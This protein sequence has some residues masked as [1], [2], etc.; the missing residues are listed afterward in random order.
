VDEDDVE[1]SHRKK[2]GFHVHQT[3]GEVRETFLC[4]IRQVMSI[5]G[6]ESGR[7]VVYWG[8]IMNIQ[9]ECP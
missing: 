8:G 1:G 6:K 7:S 9:I 5:I 3:E 4:M 2:K